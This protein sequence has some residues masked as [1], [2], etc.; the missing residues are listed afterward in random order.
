MCS[1]VFVTEKKVSE[2]V[3]KAFWIFLAIFTWIQ[4]QFINTKPI[5]DDNSTDVRVFGGD[6]VPSNNAIAGIGWYRIDFYRY[7]HEV[8]LGLF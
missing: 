6:E 5:N 4:P 1:D 2:M 8:F 7:V 3:L